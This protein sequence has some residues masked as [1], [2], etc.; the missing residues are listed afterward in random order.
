MLFFCHEKSLLKENMDEY[1][2]IITFKNLKH[3][4]SEC[5]RINE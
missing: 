1:K 2:N 4:T 3:I 5:G